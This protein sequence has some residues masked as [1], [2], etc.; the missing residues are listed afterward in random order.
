MSRGRVF[1]AVTAAGVAATVLLLGGAL[2]GHAHA[3]PVAILR[4]NAVSASPDAAAVGQLLRGLSAGNT[5][6]L[7]RRLEHRAE[8]QPEDPDTLVALGLAYQQRA[9]ETGDPTYYRLSGEALH[10]A[11]AAGGSPALIAQGEASLANTRHRFREGLRLAKAAVGLGPYN[12]SAYGALGDALL[13]LGRYREAFKAYDRMALL[14]PGIASFTRVGG[15]RELTGRPDAAVEADTLA[16]ETGETVPE[17]V[18]WTMT[19]IG[20]VRFNTGRL[21]AAAKQYRRALRRFPA[22]VHADAGLARVEASE[23]RYREAVARLRRVVARLPIPAYV[24]MLGDILHASGRE[25]EARQEY[26]LVGAIEKLFAANG[27][28]TELQTAVF[29]IDHRRN[30]DD[31]LAR[32]RTAYASAPGIYSEDALAWGLYRTRRCNEANAHSTHALRL[33]TRDALLVFHHAMIERCL[34]SA[35]ARSWFRRTLEINPHFS[36]LWAPVARAALAPR[37]QVAPSPA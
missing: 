4:A 1:L 22:Y 2:A 17:N 32:A 29:D 19:Q 15:A 35:S 33:G 11:N 12:G 30:L 27:V 6:E 21:D 31:A 8:T 14:S 5:A 20:N 16:L 36:F 10:R 7:L 26:A 18:A 13:N 37:G 3:D 9:R 28:R 25:A 23:G 24:I 34:G